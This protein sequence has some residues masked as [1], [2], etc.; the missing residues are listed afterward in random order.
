MAS[1]SMHAS[2]ITGRWRYS[3]SFD[4]IVREVLRGQR[5]AAGHAFLLIRRLGANLQLVKHIDD[6]DLVAGLYA[7]MAP[8][9]IA[10]T[11]PALHIH[12]TGHRFTDDLPAHL[13]H[14]SIRTGKTGDLLTDALEL[15]GRIAR[16]VALVEAV[17][18]IDRR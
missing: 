9:L 16:K 1:I 13:P 2:N 15:L 6:V 8:Q 14:K 5:R 18:D 10:Q 7:D 3:Q 4:I 17:R 12:I 11:D